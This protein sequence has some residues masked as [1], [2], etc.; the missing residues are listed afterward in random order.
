MTGGY[1]GYGVQ[2]VFAVK[3]I[4]RSAVNEIDFELEGSVEMIQGRYM[5]QS[6][7]AW[8]GNKPHLFVIGGKSY[9]NTWLKSVE[10]LN[11][12]DSPQFSRKQ[13]KGWNQI[14]R[15]HV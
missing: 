5:H 15:A 10:S 3:F 13:F 4:E 2:D 7:I 8:I 9:S 14:G 6:C 11:L 12:F 1:D